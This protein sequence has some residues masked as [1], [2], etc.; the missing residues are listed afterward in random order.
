MPPEIRENQGEIEAAQAGKLP[1][2]VDVDILRGELHRHVPEAL[3]A[4]WVEALV[5]EA[6]RRK[7]HYLGL[8]VAT[9]PNAASPRSQLEDLRRL[10]KAAAPESLRLRAGQEVMVGTL[11][12]LT[13][14]FASDYLI[15][16]LDPT[17]TSGPPR[18]PEGPLSNRPLFMGHLPLAPPGGDVPR[19]SITPWIRWCRAQGV[20]LDM[21]LAGAENGLDAV[22]ARWAQEAGVALVLS[23]GVDDLS[24]LDLTLGKARRGWV[25]AEGVLNSRDDGAAASPP[26]ASRPKRP[27]DDR[28]N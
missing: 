20:A 21:T 3:D 26:K 27:G 7:F 11:N 19:E 23:G 13:P 12:G 9:G 24:E 10:W 6:R 28:P 4:A 8:V 15:G 18:P 22:A 5:S 16:L 25:S 14:G 17:A 1:S 2:L